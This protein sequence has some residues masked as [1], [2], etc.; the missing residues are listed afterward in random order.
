MPVPQELTYNKFTDEQMPQQNDPILNSPT[1][2]IGGMEDN[3]SRQSSGQG[4][5][6]GGSNRGVHMLSQ[7]QEDVS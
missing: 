6:N 2:S 4:G 5:G 7:E 1:G 3:R